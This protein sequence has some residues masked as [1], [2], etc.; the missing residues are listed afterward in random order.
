MLL[1]LGRSEDVIIPLDNFLPHSVRAN[2][3]QDNLVGFRLATTV[4]QHIGHRWG[5]AKLNI[6]G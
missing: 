6:L 1:Q 3:K 4:K 2:L 5:D